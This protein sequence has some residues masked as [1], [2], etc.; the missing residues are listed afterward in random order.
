MHA[1]FQTLAACL[2]GLGLCACG[3]TDPAE[4][5]RP[6]ADTGVAPPSGD[7]ALIA[8]AREVSDRLGGCSG[9]TEGGDTSKIVPLETSV[10]AMIT[11]NRGEYSYTDRLFV[12]EGDAPPRLLSLPDYGPEGWFAS[13][14]AGM[15]ELDAGTG[16]LTTLNKAS[17]D[18]GCGSEARYA[19][20][21]ETFHLQEMRWRGCDDTEATGP[22]FPLIWPTMAGSTVDPAASTPAP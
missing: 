11:C 5:A 12:M 2:L 19:W 22:A 4:T 9:T 17:G 3:P 14:Q 20:S 10:I 15:P 7:A 8:R 18:G 6:A 16:V 13:D 1:R 21:G